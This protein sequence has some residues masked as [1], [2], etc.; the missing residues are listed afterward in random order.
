VVGGGSEAVGVEAREGLLIN[1]RWGIGGHRRG[2]EA[3]GFAE[4]S[5]TNNDHQSFA[6]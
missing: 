1:G 4:Y 6:P 3:G 5:H 2:G